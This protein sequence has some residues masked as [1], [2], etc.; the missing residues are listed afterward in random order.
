M[1]RESQLNVSP[2]LSGAGKGIYAPTIRFHNGRFWMATTN[3]TDV[4]KGHLIVHAEDPAGPWSDPV[5]TTG[6]IGWDPDLSW[7]DEGQCHLAWAD[8]RGGIAHATVDPVTGQLLSET[9]LIWQGTG[10]SSPEGPHLFPRNGW[11]YLLVAEGGT[12]PGHAVTI[13]RARSVTGPYE[14]HPDG[15]LL[16]HRSTS[17][18]VQNTGHADLVDLPDGSWAMV[19][20]GARPLGEFPRFHA[21]G[22]ETFLTGIDW[23]EEWPVVIPDRYQEPQPATSFIEDFR[24]PELHPRWIAPG[25]SPASFCHRE[26]TVGITLDA[27]RMPEEKEAK[28]LLAVRAR[29][30]EWQVNVDAPAGDLTLIVR[31]DDSH[32][33]GIERRGDVLSARAV[34]GPLDQILAS[35]KG[36]PLTA[37]LALRAVGNPQQHGV[38]TGPDRVELGYLQDGFTVLATIDGRYLSTEVAGG[39]TGRVIGVEALAGQARVGAFEYSAGATVPAATVES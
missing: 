23:A 16:T 33:A 39:F 12:G 36:M 32:W 3:I 8:P 25:V 35:A 6:A 24:A 18:P 9:E 15:P 19:Y 7:D 38:R 11:W 5:Y 30:A 14:A 37:P 29:D 10:L 20:L 17:H 27:G 22:R 4:V 31:V 21:N 13:G 1:D 28:R 26:G 2:G 34:I